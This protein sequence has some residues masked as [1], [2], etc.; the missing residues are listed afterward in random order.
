VVG[1]ADSRL[2]VR[3]D[4]LD[5]V[6]DARGSIEYSVCTCRWT[7]DFRVWRSLGKMTGL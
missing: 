1:D 6:R 2:A 7:K 3:D 4:L 5:D